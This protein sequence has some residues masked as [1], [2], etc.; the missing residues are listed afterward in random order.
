MGR[1]EGPVLDDAIRDIA[2]LLALAY[3]RR[4]RI[5]LVRT[6]SEQ[7]PASLQ[8][9]NAGETSVHELRLTSMR[10]EFTQS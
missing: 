6:A 5:P 10:K 3:K 9:A 7:I 2:S 4:A 8:L 1:E